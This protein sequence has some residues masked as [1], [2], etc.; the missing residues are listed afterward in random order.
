MGREDQ[1]PYVAATHAHDARAHAPDSSL[2]ANERGILPVRAVDGGEDPPRVYLADG[3]RSYGGNA[4][5]RSIGPPA[6]PTRAM[7]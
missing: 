2:F 5:T 6:P 3:E 1:R 4:F 7:P